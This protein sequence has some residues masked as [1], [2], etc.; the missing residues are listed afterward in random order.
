MKTYIYF[1][2]AVSIVGLT[3]CDMDD[4]KYDQLKFDNA[5]QFTVQV[6]PLT[7]DWSGFSLAPDEKKTL[8]K[9]DN[10]DFSWTPLDKVELGVSSTTR[11]VIFVNRGTEFAPPP[12]VIFVPAEEEATRR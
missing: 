6:K 4:G 3:G 10:P 7:T 8:Y 1:L 12:T 2:M 11:S 9:I 5:S